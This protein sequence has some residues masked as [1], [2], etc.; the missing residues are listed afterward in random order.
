MKHKHEW[1]LMVADA[2]GRYEKQEGQGEKSIMYC[3]GKIEKCAACST[4][5]IVPALGFLHPVEVEAAA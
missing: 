1:R 5:R 2:I 3:R 4:M